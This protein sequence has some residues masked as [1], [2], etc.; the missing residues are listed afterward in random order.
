[1]NVWRGAR[2]GG[3]ISCV[4]NLQWK[5]ELHSVSGVKSVVPWMTKRVLDVANDQVQPRSRN[6]FELI[7]GGI[8]C[9]FYRLAVNSGYVI[10]VFCC[11]KRR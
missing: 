10:F 5:S 2:E 1:M 3:G 8:N 7:E 4:S 6:R 9:D 11:M